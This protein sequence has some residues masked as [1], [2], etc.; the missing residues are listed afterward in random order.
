MGMSRLKHHMCMLMPNE[1]GFCRG[2]SR[3][4]RVFVILEILALLA[5][6]AVQN[7]LS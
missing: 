3:A 5:V 7:A 6:L 4:A 2:G 1:V